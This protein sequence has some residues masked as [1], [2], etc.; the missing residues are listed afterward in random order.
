M[1]NMVFNKFHCFDRDMGEGCNPMSSWHMSKHNEVEKCRRCMRS[2]P[3][4]VDCAHTKRQ[5][6]ILLLLSSMRS[7]LQVSEVGCA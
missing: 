4:R 7:L 3:Q 1:V 2:N 6:G 5:D